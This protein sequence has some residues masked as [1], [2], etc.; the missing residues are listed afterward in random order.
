MV[1]NTATGDALAIECDGPTHFTSESENVY[2]ESDVE[3]QLALEAAGWKFER[4]R[5]SDWIDEGF[6][7]KAAVKSILSKIA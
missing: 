5:Y 4:L 1:T 2:I 7:K 6:D 3:R